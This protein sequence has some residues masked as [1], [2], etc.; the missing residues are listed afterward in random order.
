MLDCVMPFYKSIQFKEQKEMAEEAI[1]LRLE[2][3]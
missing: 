3:N 1:K 2:K